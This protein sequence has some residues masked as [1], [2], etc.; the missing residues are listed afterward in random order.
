MYHVILYIINGNYL[1]FLIRNLENPLP[2]LSF[3]S[4]KSVRGSVFG[5]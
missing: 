2:V 1:R 3:D 5:T 4:V